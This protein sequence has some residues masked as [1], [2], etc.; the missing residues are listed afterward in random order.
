MKWKTIW[1]R[2]EQQPT[3]HL[4]I[5]YH[6]ILP[7]S[8]SQKIHD[9][10]S[11]YYAGKS[12]DKPWHNMA[13]VIRNIIPKFT[14]GDEVATF[15]LTPVH[16]PHCVSGTE[17]ITSNETISSSS[18]HSSKLRAYLVTCSHVTLGI[19]EDKWKS[20]KCLIVKYYWRWRH[21]KQQYKGADKSL[22]RPTSWCILFDGE[23]TLFDASL[24]IYR[25]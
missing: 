1:Q 8:K 11:R 24:I 25:V 14:R 13:T 22:A 18:T 21:R 20:P 23:N 3:Q 17:K 5:N 15:P 7:N 12:Q 4:S 2:T 10:F 16:N 19:L 6:F 9:D